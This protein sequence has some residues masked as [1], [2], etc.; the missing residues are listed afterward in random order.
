MDLNSTF[1]SIMSEGILFVYTVFF[2]RLHKHQLSFFQ[3]IKQFMGNSYSTVAHANYAY[4]WYFSFDLHMLHALDRVR[5]DT[6][7]VSA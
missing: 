5:A 2:R 4:I 6:Y 7:C 1:N 3:L